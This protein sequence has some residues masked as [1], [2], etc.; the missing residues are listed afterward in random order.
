MKAD[1]L[2]NELRR[3]KDVCLTEPEL[4]AYCDL[5][6]DPMRRARVEA[7]LKH[8]F[9]CERKLAMLQ[10][11]NEALSNPQITDEDIAL[12]ERLMEHAPIS[13]APSVTKP[14]GT[15][16]GIAL[17]ER[18]AEYLR[19]ITTSWRA[20][21]QQLAAVRGTT[22]QGEEVW[23]WQSQDGVLQVSAILE[24]AD[25]TIHFSSNDPRLEGAR[26]NIRLGPLSW[27]TTLRRIADSEIHAKIEITR[28]QRPKNLSDLSIEIA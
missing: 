28:Y 1:D 16:Q 26:L 17:P 15:A 27:E 22:D 9:I 12:V 8:C 4:F 25:L 11:E 10:E 23:Q 2:E 3:L 6:L 5:E 14:A 19:Q 13:S 7:H 24:N 18:L 20:H 21:F